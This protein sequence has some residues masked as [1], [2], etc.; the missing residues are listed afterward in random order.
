MLEIVFATVFSKVLNMYKML[1]TF[2]KKRHAL[3]VIPSLKGKKEDQKNARNC[4]CYGFLQSTKGVKNDQY[5]R[6][7]KARS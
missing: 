5:L 6:E 4:V 1:Y 3:K 7:K 2:E